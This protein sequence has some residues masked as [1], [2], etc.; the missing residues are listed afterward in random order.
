MSEWGYGYEWDYGHCVRMLI[1]SEH[2]YHKCECEHGE[3]LL[4]CMSLHVQPRA[5]FVKGSGADPP[6]LPPS[7][8]VAPTT[9]FFYF[10]YFFFPVIV[11]I[12]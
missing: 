3:V 1:V 5:T 2:G 8:L 11:D 10:N 6:S 7:L 12:Q 9:F 4:P